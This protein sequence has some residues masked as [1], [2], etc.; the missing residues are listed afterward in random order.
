[1]KV[2]EINGELMHISH[3]IDIFLS[4][5]SDEYMFSYFDGSEIS[6]RSLNIYNDELYQFLA[7]ALEM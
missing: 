4:N 6:Q 3:T 1:M 2:D 7:F 5:G